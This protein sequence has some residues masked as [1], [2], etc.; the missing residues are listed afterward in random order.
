MPQAHEEVITSTSEDVVEQQ[1]SPKR[2]TGHMT[3]SR[4]R[5]MPTPITEIPSQRERPTS[6][7]SDISTSSQDSEDER[8]EQRKEQIGRHTPEPM[9]GRARRPRQRSSITSA[10]LDDSR[11]V[12]CCKLIMIDLCYL[13][14]Y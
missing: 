2:D 3:R 12:D 10:E 7:Y 1:S 6:P 4:S 9:R 14:N 5:Q 13:I 8:D 11:Y